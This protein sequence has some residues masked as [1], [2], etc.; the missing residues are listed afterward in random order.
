MISNGC[1]CGNGDCYSHVA[2]LLVSQA[3]INMAFTGE[4]MQSLGQ[5]CPTHLQASSSHSI[6]VSCICFLQMCVYF[7]LLAM[8]FQAL[9]NTAPH[10]GRHDP[11]GNSPSLKDWFPSC[12]SCSFSLQKP[13]MMIGPNIPVGTTPGPS[14]IH[15]SDATP[16]WRCS[17]AESIGAPPALLIRMGLVTKARESP[18]L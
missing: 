1:C 17:C 9:E 13:C 2:P 10:R 7:K 18:W 12:N 3:D 11:S 14:H 16:L 8:G 5:R 6:F 15:C 4:H